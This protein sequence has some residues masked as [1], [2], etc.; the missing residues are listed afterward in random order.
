MENL[1]FYIYRVPSEF[2]NWLAAFENDEL[3]FL[4][5][6]AQGKKLVEDDLADFFKKFYG[7]HV[8]SFS[9]TK[10]TKK[11]FWNQKHRIKLQGSDFQVR[12]WLELVKIPRGKALTYSEL[13][14]KIR[15]PSAVRAV[16]SA[17]A[18]NPISYWIPCHRVVGKNANILKYHWGPD[19]KKKLLISE[20]Y[21]NH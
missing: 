5:S 1:E 12:V 10:W 13:A 17:V 15:K 20:G 21:L 8:G 18:K 11:N 7:F 14:K 6:Y 3:I 9:P 2:G 16:A 4:G 19:L